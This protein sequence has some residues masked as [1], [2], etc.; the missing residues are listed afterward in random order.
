LHN[1]GKNL[2]AS[3]GKAMMSVLIFSRPRPVRSRP[4]PLFQDQDRF[5]K[6]HQIIKPRPQKI[7]SLTEKKQANYDGFSQSCK[8]YA[9]GRLQRGQGGHG[10]PGFSYMVQNSRQRLNN[11]IFR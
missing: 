4:R 3:A 6:D 7:R 8:H 2:I 9:Y 10:T 11:A 1:R 5:F